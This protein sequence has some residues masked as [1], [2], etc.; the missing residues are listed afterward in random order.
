MV[1]DNNFFYNNVYQTFCLTVIAVIYLKKDKYHIFVNIGSL[2]EY[3]TCL[4]Q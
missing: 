4:L 1:T 2:V 3:D